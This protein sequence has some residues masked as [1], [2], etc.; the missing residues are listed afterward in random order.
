MPDLLRQGYGEFNATHGIGP[1]EWPHHDLFFV[2]RGRIALEFPKL[3]RTLV[4][5][6]GNGVLIWPRTLFQGRALGA[7]ARAS[8]QHF[9]VA[10]RDAEPFAALADQASGFCKSTAQAGSAWLTRCVER[11]QLARG[12]VRAWLLAVVL[13]DGGFVRPPQCT[14]PAPRLDIARLADWARENLAEN[15]GVSEL[16]A[17]V[18]LSPSRFRTVFLQEYGRSAGRF[19]VEVRTSE[20]CRLLRETREPLKAIALQLGHADPVV[21]SRA[22]KHATGVTP[23]RYRMANR[24]RG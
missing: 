17:L 9:H 18:G 7:G 21:F 22:F 3:E 23:A 12:R 10:R 5:G 11:L 1:V 20:A 19:I 14:V 8:I 16:A 13:E 15:P 24:I 2:H 6:A 4:L